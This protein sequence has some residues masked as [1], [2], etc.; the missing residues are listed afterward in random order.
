M[1]QSVQE[2]Q[3]AVQNAGADEAANTAD[4]NAQNQDTQT[5]SRKQ[6][7]ISSKH[8]RNMILLRMNWM[9]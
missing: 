2:A 7:R 5:K 3:K 1:Q 6:R 4:S 9:M 8:S